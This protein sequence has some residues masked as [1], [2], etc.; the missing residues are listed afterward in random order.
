[1]E[2]SRTCEICSVNVHRSSYAKHLRSK[3]HLEK[4]IQDELIIPELLIEEKQAPIK[5]KVRKNFNP[6][7]IKQMARGKITLDDKELAEHMINPYYFTD[8]NSKIG[9]KINLQSPHIIHANSILT[10][11][12]NF[13]D[14]GIEVRYTNKLIKELSVFYARLINQYRFKYH[15]FFSASF[16]K[17]SGD[18]KNNEIEIFINLNFNHN[19]N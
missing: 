16:Y 13:P 15:T 1:M 10:I 2:N 3:K 12:P 5:N 17:L 4:I 9:F 8:K 18:Q 19:L 14:F 7:T 6:K 11:T